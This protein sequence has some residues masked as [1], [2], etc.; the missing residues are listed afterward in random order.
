[1]NVTDVHGQE[2]QVKFFAHD[3]A[4]PAAVIEKFCDH[5][6]FQPLETCEADIMRAFTRDLN[7][8]RAHLATGSRPPVLVEGAGQQPLQPQPLQEQLLL[9]EQQLPQQALLS[10]HTNHSINQK[11]LVHVMNMTN[12]HGEEVQEFFAYNQSTVGNG[13]PLMGPPSA[14]VLERE[15]QDTEL[16]GS[17]DGIQLDVPVE[18][19]IQ[20]LS[21]S[22]AQ[23]MVSEASRPGLA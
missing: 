16:P 12:P 4:A 13:G 10:P 22:H 2:V 18:A 17:Y 1:M 15:R 11:K 3:L 6:H 7:Q 20:T 14:D 21:E 23:V 8:L 19:L 9:Q 5:H